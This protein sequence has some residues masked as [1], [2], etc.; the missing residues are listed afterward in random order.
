MKVILNKQFQS[1]PASLTADQQDTLE[2]AKAVPTEDEVKAVLAHDASTS[3]SPLIG[4][5]VIP[6]QRRAI[7]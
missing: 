4:A 2:D 6:R 1:Q 3:R 7:S 5:I